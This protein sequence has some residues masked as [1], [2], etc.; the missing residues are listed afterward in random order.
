MVV[1]SRVS[2]YVLPFLYLFILTQQIFVK[3]M[4]SASVL[5]RNVKVVIALKFFFLVWLYA[6]RCCF[7][8]V[9]EG[10]MCVGFSLYIL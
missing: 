3:I 5:E 7:H 4:S 8:C 1:Y 9:P 10:R 2:V 6:A